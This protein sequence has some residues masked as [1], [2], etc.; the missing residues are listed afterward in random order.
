MKYLP[1]DPVHSCLKALTH[2]K[3]R[4]DLSTTTM[5]VSRQQLIWAHLRHLL[6]NRVPGYR[7]THRTDVGDAAEA[8]PTSSAAGIIIRLAEPADAPRLREIYAPHAA[9]PA[10]SFEFDPPT[11]Q[12]LQRR[13]EEA[14][15]T[16]PWLV[17]V[18]GEETIGYAHARSYRGRP[19]WRWCCETSI[20]VSPEC[21]G[22]GIARKLYD[23]LFDLLKMQGYTHAFAIIM[24]PND[25]SVRLH[26]S[27]GFSNRAV[28]PKTANKRGRWYDV[29]WW[30]LTF[31]RAA[32][33]PEIPLP[34]ADVDP[35][36][37]RDILDRRTHA[38][39]RAT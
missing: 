31:G 9:G 38:L 6:S 34:F 26:E 3:H 20:Y 4:A 25:A 33:N 14:Q 32:T 24:L 39:R 11:V 17:A 27:Y 12:E 36:M 30:Q 16:H 35:G 2:S 5:T 10:V 28:M 18:R 13:I 22:Q 37:A 21:H 1:P 23:C 19:A 7:P 8:N 29:G 15:E